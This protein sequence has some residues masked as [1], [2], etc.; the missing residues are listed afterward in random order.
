MRRIARHV[1]KVR[2]PIPERAARAVNPGQRKSRNHPG[3][4]E[5]ELE[6]RITER[7]RRRDQQRERRQRDR[8]QQLDAPEEKPRQERGRRH[9]SRAQDGRALLHDSD[10][11]GERCERQQSCDHQ[12]QA[13]T[14][15]HPEEEHCQRRD[16]EPGED[17]DM[18]RGCLLES[19][20]GIRIHE[21]AVA[22]Q[23]GAQHGGARWSCGEKCIHTLEQLA[24]PARQAMPEGQRRRT[25]R[26]QQF[27]AAQE[28]TRWIP[29][30][31]SQPRASK[32]P[33]SRKLRG[34][35]AWTRASMRSPARRGGGAAPLP[36]L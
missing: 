25:Q 12:R 4:N 21:T 9:Q 22:E 5:G 8:V 23:Q 6:A 26:N 20:R 35:R 15:P 1:A 24:A 17:Q 3:S 18:K 7:G 36:A 13:Q 11:G 14:P 32:A 28:P 10:I 27:R 19:P 30:R 29:W 33:G 34:G 31:A 16:V 2:E